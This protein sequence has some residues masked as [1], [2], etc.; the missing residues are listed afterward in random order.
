MRPG[1]RFSLKPYGALWFC[2][3]ALALGCISIAPCAAAQQSP[4][5]RVDQLEGAAPSESEPELIEPEEIAPNEMAPGQMTPPG[6]T[7]PGQAAKPDTKQDGG[8]AP[9]PRSTE[10][11]KRDKLDLSTDNLPLSDPVERPKML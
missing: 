11:S 6:E 2:L 8:E 4:S 3:T 7:A 9:P 10:E 1:A 5:P